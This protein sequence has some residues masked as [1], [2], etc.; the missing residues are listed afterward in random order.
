MEV[1]TGGLDKG[2]LSDFSSDIGSGEFFS[3]VGNMVSLEQALSVLGL[4]SPDFLV[5]SEHVFWCPNSSD[6][7]PKK[8]PLIGFVKSDEGNLE[9]S[10]ARKDVERYR[11]NFSISQFFSKWEDTPDRPVFK[12]GLSEQ[13]YGL[14]HQFAKQLVVHWRQNLLATFPQRSFEFEIGDDLLDEYGVC[15]TFW[16]SDLAEQL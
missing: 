11:N 6:Y 16:Q 14:C 2:V 15:M 7:D 12:V 10:D 8:F 9:R 4:L 3:Y 13:D 5:R 1:F